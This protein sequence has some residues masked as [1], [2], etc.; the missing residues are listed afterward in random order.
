VAGVVALDSASAGF[1]A[2][3]FLADCST[4]ACPAVAGF[5]AD[6]FLLVGFFSALVGFFS[7]GF[8]AGRLTVVRFDASGRSAGAAGTT[9]SA[10]ALPAIASLD[11]SSGGGVGR[12]AV[13]AGR[14]R[15]VRFLGT[16]PD[17]PPG[18]GSVVWGS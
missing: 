9:L 17:P 5:L 4:T 2:A 1:L 13:V 14:M 18:A 11:P 6:A 15:V 8:F 3:G 7:A 12:G 10:G 16:L